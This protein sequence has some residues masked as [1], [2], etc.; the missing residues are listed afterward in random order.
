MRTLTRRMFD[1]FCTATY[2]LNS[3]TSIIPWK[4][5]LPNEANAEA[6]WNKNMKPARTDYKVFADDKNW[7]LFKEMIKTTT[8]THDLDDMIAPPFTSNPLTGTLIPFE[9]KDKGLDAARQKW[10]YKTL[11]DICKTPV[12]KR[13]VTQHLVDMDTRLV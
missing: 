13:I 4:V 10:F 7:L 6:T 3:P 12:A 11:Q 5:K 8:A 9:P 2:D 1:G